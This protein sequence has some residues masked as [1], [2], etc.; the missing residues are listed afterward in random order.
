MPIITVTRRFEWDAAHRVLG[1]EGKCRHLHG[2]RYVADVT[3]RNHDDDKLDG[4]SR[5]VDFSVLKKVVGLWIEDE[6]DHNILLHEDDPLALLWSCSHI[7]ISRTKNVRGKDIFADR[8][9][10]LFRSGLNPTAEAIA[11]ALCV[12]AQELLEPYALRV[13]RIRV[14]ETP[15][16]FADYRP[17]SP[18]ISDLA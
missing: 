14:Y 8:P 10:F 5:V 4:L 12:K 16:S 9:P 6:W 17:A 3:V 18:R 7:V 2:H 11:G 15:K 1:H 13:T